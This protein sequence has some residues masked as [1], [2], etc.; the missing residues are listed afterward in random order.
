MTDSKDTP[1]LGRVTNLPVNAS[2]FTQPKF[3]QLINQVQLLIQ[4]VLAT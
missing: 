3:Q 1:G 2:T 4:A